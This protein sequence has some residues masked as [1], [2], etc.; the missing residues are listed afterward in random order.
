MANQVTPWPG[1]RRAMLYI[2]NGYQLANARKRVATIARAARRNNVT[3]FVMDPRALPG[4]P[5]RRDDSISGVDP[6]TRESL[7]G[8]AA[9]T[10]GFAVVEHLHLDAV[11]ARINTALRR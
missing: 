3:V 6:S 4:V 8:I 1:R 5:V 11:I 7:E 10:G 2:S 9:G